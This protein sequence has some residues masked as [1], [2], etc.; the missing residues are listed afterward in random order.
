MTRRLPW[1]IECSLCVQK[2]VRL[3]ACFAKDCAE[4][5]FR[6]IAGMVRQRDLFPRSGV[7]PHF[8]TARA[9]AVKHVTACAQLVR[10]FGVLEAC[11]TSHLRHPNRNEQIDL[12]GH[13]SQ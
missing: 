3:Y 1:A 13:W 10:H 9:R 11:Q 7:T 2:V 6:H 5:T 12:R 4:R 8:V